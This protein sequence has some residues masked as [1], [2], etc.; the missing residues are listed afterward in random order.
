[1]RSLFYVCS[2]V[3]VMGLAFWAYQEN[4]QTQQALKNVRALN[5]EIGN[6]RERLAVLRA[7][8]AYL[9]RPERLLELADINF[10]SLGLLPL[11]PTQFARVDQVAYPAPDVPLIT[12]SI[13]VSGEVEAAE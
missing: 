9:N 13:E 6:G 8:W 10:D 7:E 1:M 11:Q 4:Y 3:F 12:E 2:A 5:N